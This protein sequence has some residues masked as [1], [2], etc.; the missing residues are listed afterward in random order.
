MFA[1][2]AK[3]RKKRLTQPLRKSQLFLRNR[4]EI[5]VKPLRVC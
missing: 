4:Y 5:L 3:S 1:L 2:V